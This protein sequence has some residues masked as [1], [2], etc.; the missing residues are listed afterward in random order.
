LGA[1]SKKKDKERPGVDGKG[2]D[3]AQKSGRSPVG[4]CLRMAG[5]PQRPG[6]TFAPFSFAI[7]PL[8]AKQRWRRP[9]A[10]H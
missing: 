10:T 2:L 9:E 7:S 4:P 3:E 8:A 1:G 5:G 6:G